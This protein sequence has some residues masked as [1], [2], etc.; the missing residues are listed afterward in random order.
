MYTVCVR[1]YVHV[2]SIFVNVCNVTRACVI[3]VPTSA[4]IVVAEWRGMEARKQSKA[5][6]C[7]AVPWFRPADLPVRDVFALL[8]LSDGKLVV[9]AVVGT[10]V[11][12]R[13]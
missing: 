5:V 7:P 12:T 9:G 8:L 4:A 10:F 3:F 1:I 11:L 13:V 2:S 6:T